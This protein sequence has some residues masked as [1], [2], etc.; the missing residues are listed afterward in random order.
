MSIWNT[1]ESLENVR[2]LE[3]GNILEHLE[4]EVVEIGDD[5]VRG[6]MPVDHRTHQ[7]LGIL[8]GGA[9]VVLAESLGSIASN[10]VVDSTKQ[11]A[12]GMEVNANHLRPVSK[13]YVHG[14]AKAV[15]IGRKSHVW[16]IEITND[17]GKMVCMSRLTMMVVEIPNT[18]A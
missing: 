4:I 11:Y 5:F 1:E 2:K 18:R 13:G 7:P 14:T 3:K 15:H 12:V 8:H 16:S 10:L 6:K 17:E 9:S